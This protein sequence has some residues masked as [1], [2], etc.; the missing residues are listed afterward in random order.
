MSRA[1]SAQALEGNARRSLPDDGEHPRTATQDSVSDDEQDRRVSLLLLG[2]EAILAHRFER[3]LDAEM[4][5]TE[6]RRGGRPTAGLRQEEQSAHVLAQCRCSRNAARRRTESDDRQVARTGSKTC[7]ASPGEITISPSIGASP[8]F[9][10][11]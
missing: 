11:V 6:Q 8:E 7:S 2:K 5:E 9:H 10:A 1:G 4:D 3:P